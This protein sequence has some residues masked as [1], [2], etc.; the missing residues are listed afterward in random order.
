MRIRLKRLLHANDQTTVRAGLEDR[1]AHVHRHRR[2]DTHRAHSCAL[3]AGGA[4]LG[5]ESR[6][7]AT[8]GARFSRNACSR[9]LVS[10][11]LTVTATIKLSINSP[12]S[13]S[14]RAMRGRAC[15]TAKL[16]STALAA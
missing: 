16:L 6:P 8:F 12:V 11:S 14:A 15:T 7:G 9:V 3:F 2:S 5:A 10:S 1:V 13:G 4:G